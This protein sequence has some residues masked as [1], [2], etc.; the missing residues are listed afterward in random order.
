MA[1]DKLKIVATL[2]DQITGPLTKVEG[3]L[4]RTADGTKGA[5][6][7]MRKEWDAFKGVLGQ[8]NSALSTFAAPLAALGIAGGGAALSIGAL[9][10]A[11][12]GFSQNTQQLDIL[13]K[14]TG[15]TVKTLQALENMGE[16]VG[17]S[18]QTMLGAADNFSRAATQLKRGWGEAMQELPPMNLDWLLRDLKAAGSVEEMMN[19]LFEGLPKISNLEARR[20]VLTMFFGTEEIDKIIQEYGTKAS[21]KLQE[22]RNSVAD[23]TPEARK[24]AKEFED[25]VGR[26]NAAVDKAKVWGLT[27]VLKGIV[28]LFE[29]VEKH[30]LKGNEDQQALR[31]QLSPFEAPEATPR[32]KL[33]GRRAQV[34]SQLDLL[35]AGPRGADYQRKHDRMVEEL[36]RVADELQKVREQ[37][38]TAQPSSF[39][40]PGGMGGLIQK[41]AFGASG[42]ARSFGGG[43]IYGGP[44]GGAGEGGAGG[45]AGISPRAPVPHAGAI[46][47]GSGPMPSGAG[48][49]GDGLKG[50]SAF[51]GARTKNQMEAYKAARA[52]GLSDIAARAYVANVSGES[53]DNPADY[54]WDGKHYAE[55]MVQ[56]DPQRA[57]RIAQHFGKRPRD[58][59][60]AEQTRASLWEMKNRPEYRASWEA[61][62]NGT[63]G[64][65]ILHKLIKN[66]ERPQDVPAAFNHRLKLLRRFDPN[67]AFGEG[68][69]SRSGADVASVDGIG[70]VDQRQGGGIR[71]QAITD[72]L[73]DQLAKAAKDAGVN[74]EV[75][76]GG[77]DEHGRHRTGSHRHDGG[78][79]ADVKLYTV[80]PNGQRRYLSMN[81]PADRKVMEGFIRGTVRNGATGVGSGPGYMGEHGIHIGGGPSMAW[82]AGGRSA[83]APDWVRRA[84]RDGTADRAA[85]LGRDDAEAKRAEPT[86]E[87]GDGIRGRPF[88]SKAQSDDAGEM[89]RRYYRR[90]KEGE[91]GAPGAPGAS[92][93]GTLRIKLEGAPAGTKVDHDMGGLFRDVTLSRHRASAM[94]TI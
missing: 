46:Q 67:A 34:Q 73:R 10:G 66:Y 62:Q 84:H 72:Q 30:G 49:S 61:L 11:L 52:E 40:A 23:I 25:M 45:G 80:G 68:P 91:P 27:P 9:G 50:G 59:S 55:G 13:S 47:R 2:D 82:G 81:D 92:G 5:A 36:K 60:V 64:G 20:R 53:I 43:G 42:A 51:E 85:G 83:N 19:K 3:A 35:E 29:D 65:E 31:K 71:R 28:T 22:I 33:E 16:R 76:S 58:M 75:Y 93:Q 63:N 74:A 39:E 12:R 44:G 94:D 54:H 78:R 7:S 18:G 6:V 38:A 41:A 70:G 21:K 14:Q 17:I 56:W 15:I 8:T 26:W 79:S 87:V 69:L 1:D 88:K 4:K 24:A 48:T 86:P 57:A 89:M 37:G 32:E 90:P 77:Q